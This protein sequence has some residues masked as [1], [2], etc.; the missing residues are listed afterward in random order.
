MTDSEN[1]A[2]YYSDEM[3]TF[4]DRLSAGREALGMEQKEL[5][6]RLG[7]KVKTIAAWE[8][9]VAEPRANKLQMVAGLLNVSMRWLLTGEGDG[10][11]ARESDDELDADLNALLTELRGLRSD[12]ARLGEKIGRVEKRLRAQLR[13]DK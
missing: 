1:T 8:N 5:A 4:G 13:S 11:N 3:A 6:R 2:S 10:V 12:A 7:V 9:D